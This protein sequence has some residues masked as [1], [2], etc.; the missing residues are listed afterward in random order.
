MLPGDS[1]ETNP[2]FGFWLEPPSGDDLPPG[3]ALMCEIG[4]FHE[5]MLF[6]IFFVQ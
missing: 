2:I 5:K 6:L 3:N 4:T 1:S